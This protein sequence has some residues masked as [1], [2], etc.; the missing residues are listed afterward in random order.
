MTEALPEYYEFIISVPD[1]SR[2]AITNKL[3]EMGSPGFF[4]RDG[5]I[6]AYFE[7]RPDIQGFA[8]N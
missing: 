5:N 2:E 8:M 1:E 3:M 7:Y 4:E 6:I